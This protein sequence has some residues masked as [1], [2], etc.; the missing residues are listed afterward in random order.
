[1][2]GRF[3]GWRAHARA[4]SPAG[5]SGGG[6]RMGSGE[7]C[8][9]VIFFFPPLLPRFWYGAVSPMDEAGASSA[10]ALLELEKGLAALLELEACV[11]HVFRAS[12]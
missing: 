12:V 9:A 2:P 7:P 10:A 4:L 5:G 6:R 8:R 1:M 3:T 11:A